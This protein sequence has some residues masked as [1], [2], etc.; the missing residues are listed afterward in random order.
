MRMSARTE[1]WNDKTLDRLL[2]ALNGFAQTQLLLIGDVGIDEYTWGQVRR[3]S[4]EAPVP[5]LEVSKQ[6]KRL[7]LAANVSQ[8]ILSL[9]GQVCTLGIS[10]KDAG[11]EELAALF[12][13]SGLE[14]T[15]LVSDSSR[16]TT[17]KMRMMTQHHHLLR[18]DF[19][20]TQSISAGIEKELLQKVTAQIEKCQAVILQDYG[21]GLLTESFIQAV[22]EISAQ[23]NKP[24]F[25]DPYR[26]KNLSI[27]KGASL[28]KPNMEESLQLAGI[29]HEQVRDEPEKIFSVGAA[30]QKAVSKQQPAK[31]AITRGAE[32]M[33]L[34]EGDQ[35]IQIPT[36]S[37]PVF[38]VTGAGDTAIAALAL[39][40]T[41]GLSF[42]ES[43]MLANFA[44]GI[45]VGKVGSV[46]CSQA[47][48]RELMTEQ[49][50]K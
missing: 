24:V 19:E 5:V 47:E 16:K 41:S 50:G 39:G 44:A 1:K 45:V 8:N 38:D 22:M 25:V 28:I 29:S 27:Y 43:A 37:R 30:I 18:V 20:S 35:V 15:I 4:P 48:L 34:F 9:G 31:V 32:G 49:K 7:G 21:K 10:G 42:S 33:L 36:L 6:E 40:L 12:Q 26:S 2:N 14:N 46:P 11:G 3:I 23:K 13:K 17:Q